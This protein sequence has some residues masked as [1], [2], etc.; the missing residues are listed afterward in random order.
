MP[1][2]LVVTQLGLLPW[3]PCSCPP[4]FAVLKGGSAKAAPAPPSDIVNANMAAMIN[5][6]IFLRICFLTFIPHAYTSNAS[7]GQRFD[8]CVP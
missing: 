3:Q 1:P 7:S 4:G 5:I 2:G 6:V 8:F